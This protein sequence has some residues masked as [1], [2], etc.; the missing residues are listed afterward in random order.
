MSEASRVARLVDGLQYAVG[1]TLTVA[2]LS[3]PVSLLFGAGLTGVKY[4]LFLFGLVAMGYATFLA[5]PRS[6]SDLE[7]EGVNREETRFQDLIRRVPPAAWFPLPPK[8]R[9]LDWVRLYMATTVLWLSS[10]GLEAVLGV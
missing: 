8:E 7:T 6:P 5:W 9:Y 10:F 1:L 2:I 3:L 4:G